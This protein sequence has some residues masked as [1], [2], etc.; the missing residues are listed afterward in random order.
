VVKSREECGGLMNWR[1]E[2]FDWK[3]VLGEV[4]SCV[5]SR[6]S[7]GIWFCRNIVGFRRFHQRE[8]RFCQRNVEFFLLESF[9]LFPSLLLLPIALAPSSHCFKK[10]LLLQQAPPPSTYNNLWFSS[11]FHWPNPQSSPISNNP[12]YSLFPLHRSHQNIHQ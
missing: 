1:W 5:L 2:S 8:G 10:K 3:R 6:R 4:L 12:L 11:N 9:S 7:W